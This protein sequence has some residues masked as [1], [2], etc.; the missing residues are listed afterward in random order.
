MSL[1][2]SSLVIFGSAADAI[3]IVKDNNTNALSLGAAWVG[4]I[5][6]PP[7]TPP[8]RDSTTPISP[9]CGPPMSFLLAFISKAISWNRCAGIL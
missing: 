4:G 3:H 2:A 7:P 6:R 5:A 1:I 9:P 8:G